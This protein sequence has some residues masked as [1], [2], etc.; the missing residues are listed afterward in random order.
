MLMTKNYLWSASCTTRVA[1]H[2]HIIRFRRIKGL[3]V[4]LALKSKSS[5][6]KEHNFPTTDSQSNCL[7]RQKAFLLN[8]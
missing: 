1:D 7:K 4:A 5:H 3:K 8:S 6:Y 2:S